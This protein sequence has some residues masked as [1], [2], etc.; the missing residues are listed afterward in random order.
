MKLF[1]FS[2]IFFFYNLIAIDFSYSFSEESCVIKDI[3]SKSN[4]PNCSEN[5]LV[6]GYLSFDS[7]FRNHKY[8]FNK[9][10][11]VDILA[12]YLSEIKNF[13]I[14][15]CNINKKTK[16]KYIINLNKT[17][18]KKYNNR[19]IISCKYKSL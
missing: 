13:L 8:I 14:N 18:V 17:G 15:Y 1:N 10:Y 7:E 5:N 19:V 6:H 12:D 2:L 3:L 11:N 4:N 9:V 16:I